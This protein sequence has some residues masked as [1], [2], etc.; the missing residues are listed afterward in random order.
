MHMTTDEARLEAQ[1]R[2]GVIRVLWATRD[3]GENHHS[4][5]GRYMV[6]VH[7]NLE[8]GNLLVCGEGASWEAAFEDADKREE[9]LKPYM[10]KLMQDFIFE[11]GVE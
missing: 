3:R 1:R 2:W 10:E 7:G 4:L 5:V 9:F 6:G 8:S 11:V